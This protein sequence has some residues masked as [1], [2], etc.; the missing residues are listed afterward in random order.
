MADR[1]AFF[2]RKEIQSTLWLLSFVFVFRWSVAAPYV[3]PTPSME[4]SIKVGDRILGNHLAYG[5][6]V[7]FVEG[8]ILRWASPNKGDVVIFKSQTG[9]DVHL[10]KRVVGTAGDHV[11]FIEGKLFLND[12]E[13]TLVDAQ[14]ARSIM[15]D[16]TD[17][18]A[19]KTLYRETLE[20]KD[21]WVIQ[22]NSSVY[23]RA[24]WPPDGT[25][26]VVPAGH[27][28]VSGDNRDNSADSRF[29]G[30]VPI[31]EIYGRAERVLWSAYTPDGKMMP[32][33]RLDRI[34]MDLD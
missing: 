12:V 17:N 24:N 25:A 26:F 31:D 22:N 34:G 9:D 15:A 5:L 23:R 8:Q 18:P 20:G 13:Q 19:K 10:V 21:H 30:P 2:S 1:K 7:P 11:K 32:R 6:Q 3:V 29:W 33:P 27:V 4:P 28:F 16:M 14:S